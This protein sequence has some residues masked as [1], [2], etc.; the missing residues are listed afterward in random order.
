MSFLTEIIHWVTPTILVGGIVTYSI[1]IRQKRFDLNQ[2]KY[3]KIRLM[4]SDLLSIWN[5]HAKTERFLKSK[6]PTNSV[7]YQIPEL[8]EQ[9]FNLNQKK[10]K[11]MNASFLQSLENLKEIDVIL[12]HKL[13]DSQDDFNRT[14]KEIFVPLLQSN[15][16]QN[17]PENG[18][19]I[20]IMDELMETIE[21]TIL[22]A[23]K[24]LPHRERVKVRKTLDEHLSQVKDQIEKEEPMS[25]VPEFLVKLFNNRVKPKIPFTREDF[26]E[27]YSDKTVQWVMS[28]VLT[29]SSFRK[30]LFSKSD[31]VK[32]V[33]ALLAGNEDHFQKTFENVEENEFQISKEEALIFVDNKPFYQLIM[34][35]VEK[36]DGQ[37]P[38][39]LKRD[40]VRLNTGQISLA[41][42]ANDFSQMP[43]IGAET[44]K[45][46]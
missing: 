43:I 46:K 40:L 26:Q 18:V 15:L 24:H 30:A 32:L 1:G 19:L 45:L 27:F 12:F 3:K 13:K 4:V 9:F 29:I 23:I 7:I 44:E 14:N 41:T 20:S 25:E 5:E 34:G 21:Q 10:L 17:D 31:G 37:I 35:F 42:D 8:A 36:V 22:D 28:K 2:E 11:K 33:F 39:Q 38:L 6:D 16:I